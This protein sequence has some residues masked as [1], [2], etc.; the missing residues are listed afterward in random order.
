MQGSWLG[1]TWL[2]AKTRKTYSFPMTRSDTTLWVRLY[3]SKTVYHS[4]MWFT[5]ETFKFQFSSLAHLFVLCRYVINQRKHDKRYLLWVTSTDLV[6]MYVFNT[7]NENKW[8]K[9]N[10]FFWPTKF[11]TDVITKKKEKSCI[12]WNFGK[13]SLGLK[14]SESLL[15]CK[16]LR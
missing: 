10:S 14:I 1:P 6:L 12:L 2:F 16:W 13:W 8:K 5:Q 3:W 4:F 11:H 7:V 9:T 15:W